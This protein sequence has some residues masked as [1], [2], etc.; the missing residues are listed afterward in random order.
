MACNTGRCQVSDA[1]CMRKTSEALRSF[2]A[3]VPVEMSE[4]LE[5]LASESDRSVSAELRIAVREHLK[6]EGK[7][8]TEAAPCL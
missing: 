4:Q 3:R 1:A 5:Q 6:R 2:T 7:T 8:G